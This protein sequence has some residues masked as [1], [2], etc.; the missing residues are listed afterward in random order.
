MPHDLDRC[1]IFDALQTPVVIIDASYLVSDANV[2]FCQAYGVAVADVVGRPCYDVT[3]KL[4]SP[5]WHDGQPCPLKQAL[6][7]PAALPCRLVHRHA[8]ADGGH[9]M[10]EV[11][12]TAVL[13]DHGNVTHIVEELHDVGEL[14]H[15]RGVINEV[16]EEL[17]VLRGLVHMCANC[18]MI[19]DDDGHW[20]RVEEYLREHTEAQVSHGLC[21]DCLKLLYPEYAGEE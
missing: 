3:H 4:D 18:H 1:R 9:R 5:R 8:V 2:A 16:A 21:P 20:R 19:R 11:C 7:D 10:E 15:L 6:D 14:L 12:A 17:N 13:D